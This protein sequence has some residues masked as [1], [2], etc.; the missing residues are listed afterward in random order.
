MIYLGKLHH[1]LTV[2][3]SPIDDGE[4]KGESSPFMAE[5]CRLVIFSYLPRY[6]GDK[7]DDLFWGDTV[8]ENIMGQKPQSYGEMGYNYSTSTLEC[9]EE[10]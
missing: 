4:C 3:P 5:L 6:D 10:L 7:T 9:G 8:D 1:D 2:R